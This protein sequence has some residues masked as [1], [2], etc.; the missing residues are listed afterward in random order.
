M[1][2]ILLLTTMFFLTISC[3][4]AK[5]LGYDEKSVVKTAAVEHN[6]P[7]EKVKVINKIKKLGNSTYLLEICGERKVYKT[8]GSVIMEKEKVGEF[9][10][11]SIMDKN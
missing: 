3:S 4:S 9:I 7:V 1:K 10:K 5:Y 8:V 2:K 6:C 11:Q